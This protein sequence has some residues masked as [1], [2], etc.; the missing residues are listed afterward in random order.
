MRTLTELIKDAAE[1]GN[2][3]YGCKIR[4]IESTADQAKVQL[5]DE[6]DGD[7][8]NQQIWTISMAYEMVTMI[9]D[10]N[11]TSVT[12]SPVPF[13]VFAILYA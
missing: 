11:E 12:L 2:L 3:N 1:Y 10:E 7:A 9:S 5:V 4:T 8:T 13:A 6:D